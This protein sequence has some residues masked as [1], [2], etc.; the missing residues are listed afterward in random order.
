MIILINHLIGRMHH[1]DAE[2]GAMLPFQK[3]HVHTKKMKNGVE[4]RTG[5][6]SYTD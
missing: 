5:N 4:I 1:S 2:A 3:K 6:V